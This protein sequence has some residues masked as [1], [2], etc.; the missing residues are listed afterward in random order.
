MQATLSP[1]RTTATWPDLRALHAFVTVCEQGSM[2]LA[3]ARLG[4]TQSAVSQMIKAL[5]A[6]YEL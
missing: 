5:E 2:S 6:C 4:V 3:A 1:L